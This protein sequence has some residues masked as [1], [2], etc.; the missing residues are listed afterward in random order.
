[1]NSNNLLNKYAI[2]VLPL[3]LIFVV[4]TI[5]YNLETAIDLVLKLIVFCLSMLLPVVLSAR[6]STFSFSSSNKSSELLR[7]DLSAFVFCAVQI[8]L[9]GMGMH[10]LQLYI[11]GVA[12][13]LFVVT[14]LIFLVIRYF[15]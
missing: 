14:L 4:A 15:G 1:M 12:I 7:L 8:V 11:I 3:I 13:A 10:Q 6:V 9:W 5:E 2:Y